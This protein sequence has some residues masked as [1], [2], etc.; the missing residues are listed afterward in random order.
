MGKPAA[1]QSTL[2][3]PDPGRD[4][5]ARGGKPREQELIWNRPL[6]IKSPRSNGH[7]T[8]GTGSLGGLLFVLACLTVPVSSILVR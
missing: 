7:L 1:N 8:E 5:Q 6:S 4:N 2:H 3:K